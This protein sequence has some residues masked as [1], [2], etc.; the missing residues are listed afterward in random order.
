MDAELSG[1]AQRCYGHEEMP[2]I[3]LNIES[4][5]KRPRKQRQTS[6]KT[7]MGMN[8]ASDAYP[9]IQLP[10]DSP[11][12]VPPDAFYDEMHKSLEGQSTK[13]L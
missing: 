6:N 5:S 8:P 3:R 1:G 12:H 9:R 11:R 7:P 13:R 4:V 2:T 10:L